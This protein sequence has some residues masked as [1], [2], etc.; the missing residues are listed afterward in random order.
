MAL[1][2]NQD[3][4]FD[5]YVLPQNMKLLIRISGRFFFQVPR[6]L[7]RGGLV[8]LDT[9]NTGRLWHSQVPW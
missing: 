4:N 8:N 3:E 6:V 1:V 7:A 9:T 2:D 5:D